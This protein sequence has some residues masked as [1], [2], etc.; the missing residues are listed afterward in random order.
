[1]ST[2]RGTHGAKSVSTKSERAP[3]KAAGSLPKSLRRQ[4]ESVELTHPD[5]IL[6]PDQGLTKLDLAAY[7][8]QVS[9][10]MLPYV[11][12][13]P[14]SGTLPTWPQGAMFLQKHRS[15][16]TSSSRRGRCEKEGVA[17]VL[18]FTIRRP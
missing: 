4:L 16:K 13:R 18:P 14:L 7:Y 2:Q 5:R 8:V 15:G 10:L 17:E 11:V 6:Y 1:M 12:D 3:R 9:D